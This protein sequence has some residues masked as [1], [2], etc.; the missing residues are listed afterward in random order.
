MHILQCAGAADPHCTQHNIAV[1]LIERRRA[2]VPLHAENGWHTGQGPMAAEFVALS[3]KLLAEARER[4]A[5]D[6]S[7]PPLG[8]SS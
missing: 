3:G 4:S 6:P 8:G 1:L 5:G 7:V 2:L